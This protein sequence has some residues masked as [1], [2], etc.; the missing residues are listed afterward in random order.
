MRKN[1]GR[2]HGERIAMMDPVPVGIDFKA[3]HAISRMVKKEGVL[4]V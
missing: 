3:G 2:R 4:G 1:D